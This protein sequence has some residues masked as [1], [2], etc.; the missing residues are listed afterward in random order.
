MSIRRIVVVVALALLLA[1]AAVK[2]NNLQ[3]TFVGGGVCAAFTPG[4]FLTDDPS[5]GCTNSGQFPPSLSTLTGALSIPA[6]PSITG[7]NLGTVAYTTGAQIGNAV[8]ILINGK[9][10]L[11]SATYGAGGNL[12]VV[13]GSSI[14]P[15]INAGDTLFTGVFSSNTTLLSS[16]PA[17]PAAAGTFYTLSGPVTTNSLNSALLSALGLS[18]LPGGTATAIDLDVSFRFQGGRV[19]SGTITLV[20]EPAT[21]SLL[22]TGLIGLAGLLRRRSKS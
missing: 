4:S 18:F 7:S 19:Q 1:P 11:V 12:T 5:A 6:G 3:F 15:G 13:A 14:A 9:S 8:T 10:Q 17:N 16:N 2:A 21:L 20:P 22:G